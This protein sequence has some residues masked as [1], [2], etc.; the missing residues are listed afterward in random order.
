[1]AAN[2]AQLKDKNDDIVYPLTVADAVVDS[3]SVSLQ[4]RVN[5]G[6]FTAPGTVDTPE[7]WVQYAD[8]IW[9]GIFDKI[10]PVGSIFMSATLTTAADVATALGGGTWVAWGAGRVPVGMGDN[11]TTDYT[12][13]EATGGQE[14]SAHV[15]YRPPINSYSSQ[16]ANEAYTRYQKNY[17]DTWLQNNGS[18]TMTL[19]MRVLDKAGAVA[20]DADTRIA[21]EVGFWKYGAENRQPYITCYMYKRTA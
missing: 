11:G 1:M 14:R 10:Y 13:V 4:T 21:T 18:T 12:T 15:M 3:D 8:L 7:P 5:N 9:S 16:A 17:A 19:D 2:K 20:G 6:V